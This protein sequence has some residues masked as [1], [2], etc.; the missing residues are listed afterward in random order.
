MGLRPRIDNNEMAGM[1]DGEEK[2]VGHVGMWNARGQADN[3]EKRMGWGEGE[4]R[5]GSVGKAINTIGM[6]RVGSPSLRPSQF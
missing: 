2:F 3:V 1:V 5:V 4:A 6:A